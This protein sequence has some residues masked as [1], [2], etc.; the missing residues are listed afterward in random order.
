MIF[1]NASWGFRELALEKQLE[2]TEKMGLQVLELAIANAPNDLSA[3][4]DDRALECVRS[5]YQK[6]HIKLL[7]AATGNDFTVGSAA[8]LNK[9]QKV[10]DICAK[11]KIRYLRIFAGFSPVNDVRGERFEI[12]LDCLKKSCDYAESRGVTLTLETH[13]GVIGHSD[14]VEHIMSVTTELAALKSILNAVPK[15]SVNYDPANLYAVGISDQAAFFHAIK[16]RVKCVHLKD[17]VKL[18]SGHLRPAACGDS[19]FDWKTVLHLLKDFDGPCLFEYELPENIA[20]GSGR[21]KSYI[22]SLI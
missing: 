14:G 6:H 21:C 4:A 2:I 22:E 20:E 7:C 16:D 1:G 12:L 19:D 13:G 18:P 9:L 5:L 3:D 10:I 8:D 17:F 11:L 15:L